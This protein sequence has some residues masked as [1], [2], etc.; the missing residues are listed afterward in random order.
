[1][2]TRPTPYITRPDETIVVTPSLWAEAERYAATAQFG[3]IIIDDNRRHDRRAKQTHRYR[4]A[5]TH[6]E[7]TLTVPVKR[8]EKASEDVTD[9]HYTWH[10]IALSEHGRWWHTHRITI[11]SAYG[12]TPF[13][14][15]Y[16]DRMAHLFDETTVSKFNSV[17]DLC[18]EADRVAR[19]ILGMDNRVLYTSGGA[20]VPA[21]A[22]RLDDMVG[23][24]EVAP[25][26]QVRDS[27]HGFMPH[28]SV[29]DIIFNL[30]PEAL[31]HLAASVSER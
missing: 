16:I 3:T 7:V 26:Y 20:T 23:R 24:V 14:Q 25:Y 13:M 2:S 30:G 19:S 27:K 17:A 22:V 28:L 6:G 15:F 4:I 29:L 9:N 12:R 1:M 31:P 21:D 18:I 11:E 8:P 10:D 5:D